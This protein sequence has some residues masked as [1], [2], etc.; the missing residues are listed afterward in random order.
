MEGTIIELLAVT[1]NRVPKQALQKYLN[2]YIIEIQHVEARIRPLADVAQT[3]EKLFDRA[4]RNEEHKMYVLLQ[5]IIET[6]LP[7]YPRYKELIDYL[8]EAPHDARQALAGLHPILERMQSVKTT[9][10]GGV[11][12]GIKIK[13]Q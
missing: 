13:I 10:E 12:P 1:V 5:D 2:A 11:T 3:H 7:G 6:L 8:R 9:L 4:P